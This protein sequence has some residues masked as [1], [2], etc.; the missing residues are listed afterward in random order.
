MVK[1]GD[2]VGIEAWYDANK[3]PLRSHNCSKEKA[4]WASCV[5]TLDRIDLDQKVV[6]GGV[7]IA[8]EFESIS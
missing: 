8:L 1:K 2:V 7:I 5:S 3:Y 6:C 4:N